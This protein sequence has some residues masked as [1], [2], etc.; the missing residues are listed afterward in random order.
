MQFGT[1]GGVGEKG[2]GQASPG[3]E[4]YRPVVCGG[5]AERQAPPSPHWPNWPLPW[6]PTG[7]PSACLVRCLC[8]SGTWTVLPK[9]WAKISP[10]DC[11]GWQRQR[12][13][14]GRVQS[15]LVAAARAEFISYTMLKCGASSQVLV[16]RFGNSWCSAPSM[17]GSRKI[18]P[19]PFHLAKARYCRL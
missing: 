8:L 16:A 1:V 10:A 6:R 3:K 15:W 4:G 18:S 19:C 13:L 17:Q 14:A 7:K 2:G 11:M 5:H 9:L 12:G